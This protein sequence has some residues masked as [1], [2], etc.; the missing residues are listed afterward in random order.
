MITLSRLLQLLLFRV[1]ENFVEIT[2]QTGLLWFF[3]TQGETFLD[4]RNKCLELQREPP[5]TDLE[6]Y[7]HGYV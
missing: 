4:E 6:Q 1:V 3:V 2:Q 5:D 7:I